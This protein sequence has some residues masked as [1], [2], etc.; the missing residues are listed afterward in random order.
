MME[1]L[2]VQGAVIV[3]HVSLLILMIPRVL[4]RY[5]R[6]RVEPGLCRHAYIDRSAVAVGHEAR[7]I[8]CTFR[9]LIYSIRQGDEIVGC[10][11]LLTESS[12]LPWVRHD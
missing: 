9:R 11:G 8:D 3:H 1:E 12:R 10:Y 5:C 7:M 4:R 6:P 2:A